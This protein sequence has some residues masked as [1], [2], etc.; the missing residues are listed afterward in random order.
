MYNTTLKRIIKYSPAVTK[1][2][3]WTKAEMGVGADIAAGNQEEKGN[4][5]DFVIQPVKKTTITKKGTDNTL[6]SKVK[7]LL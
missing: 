5:A 7:T 2:E 6:L 1:V 4:K 3:E